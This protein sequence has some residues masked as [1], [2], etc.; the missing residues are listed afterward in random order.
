MNYV[1]QFSEDVLNEVRVYL[2]DHSSDSKQIPSGMLYKINGTNISIY[3][4]GKV[5]IQGKDADKLY[6]DLLTLFDVNKNTK[7]ETTTL[8]PNKS[9]AQFDLSNITTFP[10]IGSDES[11]KGD[12]FGP[13][14][15]AAFMLISSD[16]EKKLIELGVTDSKK[17]KDNKILELAPI[18]KRLGPSEVIRINPQKYN[19]LYTKMNNVNKVLGWSHARAIEN[20]LVKNDCKLAIADKFGDEKLIKN[21]LFKFGKEVE[22]IQT[23]KAERDTAVAAASIL[24][25]EAF[26]KGVKDLSDKYST[27]LPLGAGDNVINTGTIYARKNGLESLNQ[28]AKV[29]FRTLDNIRNNL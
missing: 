8:N 19:E 25:R 26:I 28:I 7:K 13:L 4:S 20:V 11:G 22:L 9:E 21:S 24:A 10:R 18:I 16:V 3:K 5:L 1:I 6:S 14:V 27:S 17:I 29:H 15:T 23:P 2:T 12:F